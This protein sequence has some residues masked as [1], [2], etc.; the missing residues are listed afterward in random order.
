MKRRG[1]RW[2]GLPLR[3][4]NDLGWRYA[5]PV[6]D[7]DDDG[8]PLQSNCVVIVRMKD[9]RLYTKEVPNRFGDLV[10][11]DYY[12]PSQALQVF[13]LGM[14]GTNYGYGSWKIHRTVRRFKTD[15]GVVTV[16]EWYS[17]PVYVVLDGYVYR[18][19]HRLLHKPPRMLRE[20]KA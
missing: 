17:C 7:V 2:N 20:N 12:D 11:R 1:K 5:D 18:A 15:E 19:T 16:A 3:R 4:A 13:K 10:E 9:C 6:R 14:G 8:R